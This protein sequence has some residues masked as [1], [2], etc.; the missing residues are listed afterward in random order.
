VTLQSYGGLWVPQSVNLVYNRIQ[1]FGLNAKTTVDRYGFW[2]ESAYNHT[3]ASSWN[4][5]QNRHDNLAWT[6]GMDFNYGPGSVYYINI[7]YAGVWVFNYDSSALSLDSTQLTSASYVSDYTY[8]SLTQALGDQTEQML[9]SLMLRANW[10]L[11]NATITPSLSTVV[12]VPYN[13]NSTTWTRYASLYVNPEIDL[14][15]VDGLHL[16]AGADLA[17]AWVKTAGG[18]SVTL[19]TTYDRLGVYTPQNNLYVKVDY[20]WNG[21][22]GGS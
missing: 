15:P 19:D 12:A 4:D 10:P 1:R 3:A 22:L 18:S 2:L 11:N 21:S 20:K 8:R 13:Y 6:A 7:Q 14:M 5:D 16:L 9:N 17:Y